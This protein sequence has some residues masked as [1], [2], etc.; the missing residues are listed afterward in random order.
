MAETRADIRVGV[1]DETMAGLNS[2]RKNISE[3]GRAMRTTGR[4]M[5]IAGVVGVTAIMGMVKAGVDYG[6][7]MDK[8]I[9]TTRMSA[10]EIQKWRY[11]MMQEHAD[12]ESFVKGL[13]ILA[14]RLQEAG[15]GNEMAMQTFKSM[16][17]EVRNAK[18]EIKSINEILL[19]LSDFFSSTAYTAE[20]K[21][22]VAMQLLGRRGAE[23]IP[24]LALGR[25]EIK[26]LGDEAERLG[27]IMSEENVVAA[28]RFGDAMTKLTETVKAQFRA[29]G[30]GLLPMLSSW[31]EKGQR[32]V[33]WF[34]KIDP[35]MKEFIAKGILIGS[36]LLVLGGG[37]TMIAGQ[38]LLA[39][40]SLIGIAVH[41]GL[42]GTAGVVSMGAIAIK[43]FMV[44]GVVLAL[45][46]ALEVLQGM[47]KGITVG[48]TEIQAGGLLKRQ[49]TVGGALVEERGILAKKRREEGLTVAEEERYDQI[50]IAIDKI[51]TS[52]EILRK[53]A[54]EAGFGATAGMRAYDVMKSFGD[55][56]KT[57]MEDIKKMQS[58]A[59]FGSKTQVNIT[60]Y[61]DVP[62]Q[63]QLEQIR[64]SME[65]A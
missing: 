8:V 6:N 48:K 61:G 19:D 24:F 2:I 32:V 65:G 42:V 3:T 26:K 9:K 1:K 56:Q 35:S 14:R 40:N 4:Q 5:M 31:I 16:G 7:T 54:G 11:A 53:R 10:S 60:N 37:L 13:P 49:E 58:G 44:L 55:F 22:A 29:I 39:I 46:G 50:R 59:P 36:L 47:W 51:G 27:M 28:E 64:L 52:G 38:G 43:M 21:L 45:I 12:F 30:I 17:I 62:I 25:D 33:E 18:G 41:F 15:E 20:Q 23:M 63:E 57:Q 34:A